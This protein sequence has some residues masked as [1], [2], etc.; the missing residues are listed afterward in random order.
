MVEKMEIY[1]HDIAVEYALI[2][3]KKENAYRACVSKSGITKIEQDHTTEA[4]IKRVHEI[5]DAAYSEVK[6]SK[7]YGK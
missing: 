4:M 1:L 6:R 3:R 5:V 2:G 7:I